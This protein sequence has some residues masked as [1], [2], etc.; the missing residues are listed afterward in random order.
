MRSDERVDE[1]IDAALRSYAELGE[2]P[3][4]RVVVAR[5]MERARA[6]ESQ[7]RGWWMWGVAAAAG[8]AVMVLAGMVWMTRSPRRAEIAWVPRAPGVA[9]EEPYP[10]RLKPD[11]SLGLRGTAEAMPFHNEASRKSPGRTAHVETASGQRVVQVA[12]PERQPKLDVF[13]TPRPLS[14]EEQ[15]MVAFASQAPAEVKKAVIEDQQHWDD[16]I[17][18]AEVGTSP[19]ESGSQP[20]Q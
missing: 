1:R 13:P 16:P 6:A 17:I 18:V 20:N 5:V 10:Q 4:A 7:R 11:S 19:L 14:A 9:S 8:L 12:A 3:E 2:I 15:G